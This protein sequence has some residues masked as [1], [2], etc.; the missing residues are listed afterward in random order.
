V[1]SPK[2][3]S[4]QNTVASAEAGLSVSTFGSFVVRW[5]GTPVGRLGTGKLAALLAYLAV[6]PGP[7]RREALVDLFWPDLPPSAAR[8]NLRQSLFQLR[9]I[10]RAASGQDVIVAGRTTVWLA[11]D[12][13]LQVAAIDFAKPLPV[14]A[15]PDPERCSTCLGR[16]AALADL[17]HGPFLADLSVPA[18]SEF[19]E[20]LHVKREILHRQALKLLVRLADCHDQLGHFRTALPF[21]Q[22]FVALE[23]WSE[24]GHLR[25]MQLLIRDENYPAVLEQYE[26]CRRSLERELG[27]TPNK[28]LQNLA[29]QARAHLQVTAQQA[30]VAEPPAEDRRQVTVLYCEMRVVGVEEPEEALA[31]L[32]A[33]QERGEKL[34]AQHDGHV[35]PTY[36]G[37]FL[38]YFGY[39]RAVENAAV[40][41]VHAAR[42]L[43]LASTPVLTV[44]VG[45]HSGLV[46][47]S[48]A[49]GQ[50]DAVGITTS[51]AIR[52]QN[53]AGNG[54]VVV[55]DATQHR[56]HGYFH[57]G[58]CAIEQQ[59]ELPK[60]IAAFRLI[61]ESGAR[62]R[63]AAAGQLS[64]MVG[65]EVETAA[66][67][68][69]WSKVRRGE[70]KTL[71]LHGEAGIGKSRLVDS[72]VRRLG[73]GAAVVRELRC[74]PETK[75]SPLQPVIELFATQSG[76]L[77]HDT[78]QER[79]A[80]LGVLLRKRAPQL[81]QRALPLL[82]KLLGVAAEPH[83]SP[84]LCAPLLSAATTE[85]LVDLLLSLAARHSVL[86][87][88]ED[89]HWADASTLE[90]LATIQARCAGAPVLLLM[91]ARTDWWQTS[92]P[93]WVRGPDMALAPL[94]DAEAVRLIRSL[95]PDIAPERLQRIVALA[96]GIP[97]FV[98]EMVTISAETAHSVPFPVNLH[99]LLLARIDT[100]GPNRIYAQLAATIG[101][102]FDLELLG[103][104]SG[105]APEALRQIV[106]DLLASGL[107]FALEQQQF[108]FK[109]ALV[110]E[111]AY[112][113]QTLVARKAAHRK[114]AHALEMQ[115]ARYGTV[116][117]EILAQH[118][119]AAGEA[120]RAV[121]C[122]L[123][124]GQQTASRHAHR[125]AVA[126]YESGLL[127]L[128]KVPH[129]TQRD[130]QE[131][132]LLV[133]LS[134]SVQAVS[135]YGHGRST[136]LLGRATALANHSGGNRMALF[137]AIWG[138]WEGSGS[139]VD[140]A[141]AVQ[142][143][144]QMLVIAEA[145]HDSDLLQQ[146]HYALGNSLFWTGAF[147]ESR[148]HLD[149]ALA[150]ARIGSNEPPLRDCY[151]CIV[152]I[153]IKVYLSWVLWMQG[154][155]GEAMHHS[156]EA[157]ALGRRYG[158]DYSLAFAL[159]FA[160]T[161]QRWQGRVDEALCFATEGLQ[162]ARRCESAVFAA[163]L[164]MIRGW[165][166]VMHGQR[167]SVAQI[168]AGIGAI[169]TAMSAVVVPLLAPFAEALLQLGE[170]GKALDIVA[171][172]LVQAKSK[173]D[174]HYLAELHRMKGLCLQAKGFSLKA[175]KCYRD[176]LSVAREQGAVVF[177]RRALDCIAEL[178]ASD[179]LMP[180]QVSG[181]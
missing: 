117:P 11:T 72:L 70:L 160:A 136:E 123:A 98:E 133:G 83:P 91:T 159:T 8:L 16:L 85:L 164:T 27:V 153:G 127:A 76:F 169:R 42:A 9:K 48:L 22:R 168:E 88:V 126:H 19:E 40:R 116:A 75:Q 108:R 41:A 97:L 31:F 132:D 28:A 84:D 43:A 157:L 37:G 114:L 1:T 129:C 13:P 86:L 7:L 20:W 110:Q 179:S 118:W 162:V 119:D 124:A 4:F 24:P 29:D 139:R 95:R 156:E 65:R 172:A 109:H 115:S 5:N 33:P 113:S 165:A 39:P 131:F 64:P 102:E 2:P 74:F 49:R 89:L 79:L 35:V 3:L 87:V 73:A 180:D 138:L 149:E 158:D 103:A 60:G 148:A 32:R 52:L 171:E 38:A 111:A 67:F 143:A 44:R 161:L 56:A 105:L 55:S 46:L 142:L 78:D 93:V 140:H 128:G 175:E 12:S 71:L 25:V 15:P 77:A 53:L 137:H 82:A 96:D 57:F 181:Q 141:E 120:G 178:R 14:C 69:A 63:L 66:L 50:P 170:V 152:V 58:E 26:L 167:E 30:R 147:A 112:Q 101:R 100:L 45:V 23:P 173:R 94:A 151:G 99:D 134:H 36:T 68:R 47:A 121:A 107:V 144:R 62:Y 6:E 106:K 17:Y 80:K 10:L 176:A 90:V 155:T 18:A 34:V 174:H 166:E 51:I 61:A 145:K 130:G 146:A 125:E 81:A 177:E 122:W 21:A 154:C 150:L 54:E 92:R 163:V 135:G 59:Q 104:V